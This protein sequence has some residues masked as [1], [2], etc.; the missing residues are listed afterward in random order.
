MYHCLILN[1]KETW[2]KVERLVYIS[3]HG[4]CY[5]RTKLVRINFIPKLEYSLHITNFK[6]TFQNKMAVKY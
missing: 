2:K 5:S 1:K 3:D 6:K 4:L